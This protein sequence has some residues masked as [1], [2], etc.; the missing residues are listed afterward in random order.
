MSGDTSQTPS[1]PGSS[2]TASVEARTRPHPPSNEGTSF[3]QGSSRINISQAESP[4]ENARTNGRRPFPAFAWPPHLDTHLTKVLTQAPGGERDAIAS[5]RRIHPELPEDLI[6]SRI[7]YL[8][9][10]NRKRAPYRKHQWTAAEDEILRNEY[11]Q[12]RTS[13]HEAIEKILAMHPDWSR[14]AVVWRA[15]VLRLTQRRPSPHQS[16]TP[17]LD[18][19]LLSLRGC[20]ADTIAKRLDCTMKSVSGRLRRLGRGAEFF[21]GFKTKDL[22]AEL[23]I[24][25][26]AVKRWIRLGWLERKK[27]R[28]TEES[29][30]WL[31]RH[32]PEEIPFETLA[33]EVRNWLTLSLD[34][35]R[36]AVAHHGGRTKA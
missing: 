25:E 16:W 36:G 11:G 21:G 9:L 32:H 14:D 2:G 34:Y 17:T 30:R 27:G 3:S 19:Q 6:W 12:S 29:L 8:G 22:T 20:Q 1:S 4:C 23:R 35:R 33:P 24:P 31:C 26:A 18:H 5:I 28:I 7:V 13:S 10:T 15:R